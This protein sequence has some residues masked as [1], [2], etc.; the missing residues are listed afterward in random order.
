MA[1]VRS[2]FEDFGALGPP[3]GLGMLLAAP[4]ILEHGTPEQIQRLLPPI[5]DGSVG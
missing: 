1:I 3:G 4:T 5:L 2:E